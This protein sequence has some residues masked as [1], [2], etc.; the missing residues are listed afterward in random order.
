MS[1]ATLVARIAAGE[2]TDEIRANPD[3]AALVPPV[4]PCATAGGTPKTA[5]VLTVPPV[6]PVPPQNNKG[7]SVETESLESWEQWQ[8]ANPS[9]GNVTLTDAETLSIRA[10]LA[11]IG[12]HD[13][14]V[15]A[16][17]LFTC[18][19]FPDTL[20]HC[21]NHAYPVGCQS[22]V[23]ALNLVDGSQ[24]LPDIAPRIP[25]SIPG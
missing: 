12:E 23:L 19:R 21:L 25:G 8:A 7:Q 16:D 11:F 20:A 2:T 24:R 15:I 6:P 5:P 1:L 14:A 18:E 22:G 13:K 4:P 10:W 17:V 9:P 3:K